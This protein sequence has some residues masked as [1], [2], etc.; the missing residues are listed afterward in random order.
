MWTVARTLVVALS[1]A[2]GL[3]G[4]RVTPRSS[5]GPVTDA[6]VGL[7]D[8]GGARDGRSGLTSLTISPLPLTPVFEPTIHD[9]YVACA[10]GK[11]PLTVTATSAPGSTVSLLQPKIHS[12]EASPGARIDA[13]VNVGEGEALVVGVTANGAT[14]ETWIRCLPGDFPGLALTLHPD[15][16][17]PTPGYYL[18]G[19]VL[20]T[21]GHGYAML[22]DGH[23]VPVWYHATPAGL[24]AVDVDNL[25]PGVVSY[26]PYVEFTFGSVTTQFELHD[27][28]RG[29]VSR[30]ASD[31]LPLDLHEL[32]VLPNGDF[33]VIANPITT[34][35]DLTGLGTFGTNE[36]MVECDIQEVTPAG[37]SVW[38]W[39][40]I[41]H[42]DPVL[43][44]LAPLTGMADGKPF[45]DPFH[46]N[47]I[48]VDEAGD[49]LVSARAMSSVFLVARATGA[50]TWKLGGSSYT[51]D[52]ARFIAVQGDPLTSFH[53]QHDARFQPDGT[54]SMFDDQAGA[55]GP[56]RAVVYS[57]DVTAGTAALLWQ[58]RGTASSA[59]MG[60][61]RITADGSRVIGWGIGG[62]PGRAFSEVTAGGDDLLDFAF[63]G[64]DTTYR[65]I[66]V[67]LGAFDLG[68]LRGTAGTGP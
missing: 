1:M 25:L 11:N 7:H 10:T 41:D 44:S 15:A 30:V 55:P 64:G 56:A 37:A 65:A 20:R 42:F 54:L 4:C 68:A 50:V 67:P 61:F 32:R 63:S 23:G 36:N 40:A 43:D 46:C 39:Q 53:G 17:P 31:G 47:S 18:V 2:W 66:K 52:G 21:T 27:L 6:S 29:T 49:L 16:G 26:V 35:V 24:D 14:D 5:T 22:M 58:Y 8:E 59:G 51:K 48:D 34:G 28:A 38:Q 62:A 3:G 57:Y 60:S 13:T 45:V 12:N 33:L 9:Y 19:P